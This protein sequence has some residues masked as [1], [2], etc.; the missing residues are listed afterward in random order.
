M[1]KPCAPDETAP[2]TTTESKGVLFFCFDNGLIDYGKI[3]A[4]A[5]KKVKEHLDLPVTVVSNKVDLDIGQDSLVVYK[6]YE[7]NSTTRYFHEYR[8]TYP[9]YNRGRELSLELSPYRH[10]IVL[11]VD[12]LVLGKTLLKYIDLDLAVSRSLW[13]IGSPLFTAKRSFGLLE[14]PM[15]YATVM[16][17]DKET[18]VA[19][20]FF[21]AMR[22]VADDWQYYA[23]MFGLDPKLYRNDYVVSIAMYLIDEY[24]WSRDYDLPMTVVNAPPQATVHG[25]ESGSVWVTPGLGKPSVKVDRDLHVSN[26][27]SLEELTEEHSWNT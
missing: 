26:K 18:A 14:V 23:V 24:R 9:W 21:K 5:I 25:L 3:T 20:A 7:E 17:F 12:Y 16:V 2:K 11:D 13:D 8:E 6:D 4:L 1:Q 10:T 19:Q 15:Y 22:K 27:K